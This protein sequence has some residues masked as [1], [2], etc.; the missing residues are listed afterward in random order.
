MA[1]TKYCTY[2]CPFCYVNADFLSYAS[3]TIDEIVSWLSTVEAPFDIIYVSGDTDSFAPPR[4]DQGIALLN[5]LSQ[6]D[7]DILF[8]T[9]A[10]LSDKQLAQL[11]TLCADLKGKGKL[12]IG[13]V[14]VAQLTHPHLEP[15]PVPDALLRLRQLH[16]FHAAGL[17]SILAMR[18][19]LPIVA[20]S[21][22]FDI[23][24]KAVGGADIV[25]GEVWYADQAGVLERGVFRGDTPPGIE[26]SQHTMDFDANDALWKVYEPTDV[27]AAVAEYCGRQGLPFFMRS[28]PA[29]DWLRA[30]A[31]GV[32]AT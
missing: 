10:V 24:D 1:S 27:I 17:A 7:R 11:A 26:F 2:S 14:S 25:L 13:C 6:F 32:E 28:R 20:N 5:A 23:V 9:R 19:F 21:E 4:A 29:I 16:A 31:F 15:P 30:N 22:Y 18:P 12:L 8:T 3:M